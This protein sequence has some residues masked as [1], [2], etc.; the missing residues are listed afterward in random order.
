MLSAWT[1]AK[2]AGRMFSIYVSIIHVAHDVNPE[3]GT[4][5]SI[6]APLS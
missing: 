2:L 6:M 5:G 3:M 1:S 4:C